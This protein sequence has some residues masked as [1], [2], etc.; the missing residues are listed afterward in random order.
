M[1]KAKVL[2]VTSSTEKMFQFSGKRLLDS[3]YKYKDDQ[4]TLLY[5]TE[6]F[7]I[8]TTNYPFLLQ[9]DFTNNEYMLNWISNNLDIIPESIGGKLNVND[10]K[11][12]EKMGTPIKNRGFNIKAS[13]W[14]KKIVAV[15]IAIEKYM[16]TNNYDV[17]IWIDNDCELLNKLDSNF[18]N[19]LFKNDKQNM[20]VCWGEHR[21]NHPSGVETGFFGMRNN[22][23]VWYDLCKLFD[24]G[25]F[26]KSQRWGDGNVLGYLFNKKTMEKYHVNDL[27]KNIKS[28]NIMNDI[29]FLKKYIVHYKGSHGKNNID[30]S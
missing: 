4:S 30:F 9:E 28:F 6:N 19:N 27:G 29:P 3:F 16:S 21:K 18:Y 23:D 1:E 22:F 25:E 7:S 24:T 20:F 11:Q 13:L 15:K 10:S 12:M 17:L 14:F 8:D 2:Y 26:K 5:L